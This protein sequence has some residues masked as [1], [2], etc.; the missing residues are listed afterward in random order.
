MSY[1]IVWESHSSDASSAERVILCTFFIWLL[2]HRKS[3]KL[4]AL[5]ALLNQENAVSFVS[6]RIGSHKRCRGVGNNS[7]FLTFEIS[8][9]E[10]VA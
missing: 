10:Q 9:G 2:F 1:N 4:A 8:L 5:L 6:G 7:F 3:I